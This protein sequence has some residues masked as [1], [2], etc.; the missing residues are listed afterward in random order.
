MSNTTELTAAEKLISLENLTRYDENI[1]NHVKEHIETKLTE[2]VDDDTIHLTTE[3]VIETTATITS[4]FN[5]L[6]N[7]DF[8]INQ[9]GKTEYS[10]LDG[11][12]YGVDRWK[13][14]GKSI[15]ALN[16]NGLKI[17]CGEDNATAHSFIIQV[18]ENG[19]C[20]AG[21]DIT[22]SVDV[23]EMTATAGMISIWA[24]DTHVAYSAFNST[25][26]VVVTATVPAD[27]TSLHVRIDGARTGALL[28][29][30]SIIKNAKLEI[31]S[32]ATLFSPPVPAI[33][34][35]KCQRYYRQY[36][37]ITAMGVPT[38]ADGMIITSTTASVVLALNSMR[39]TPTITME[40][41]LY[42]NT[43]AYIG[44]AAIPVTEISGTSWSD[45]KISLTFD[46][47]DNNVTIGD[48][49]Q[50]TIRDADSALIINA[51]IN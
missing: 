46:L 42:I 18:V 5:L 12:I 11:A 24:N 23:S 20:Y 32:I 30:Y 35:T 21:K 36:K 6:D 19:E 16:D 8:K 49:A 41:T 26:L 4:N 7:P 48:C 47:S 10:A 39:I 9:R 50:L 43:G 33:E 38:I 37:R 44:E 34:L 15:C 51:D 28:N 2:H 13:C 14:C 17:A 25:G 22:F 31:G 3:K 45:D 29:Q 27:T 1:K 40:G